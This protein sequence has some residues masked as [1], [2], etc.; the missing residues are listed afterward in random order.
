METT[1]PNEN[2]VLEKPTPWVIRT[3]L[4]VRVHQH[5]LLIARD[6]SYVKAGYYVSADLFILRSSGLIIM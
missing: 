3:I 5:W 4:S 2:L 6:R 1:H